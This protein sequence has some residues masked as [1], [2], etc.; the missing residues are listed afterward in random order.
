MNLWG[1]INGLMPALLQLAQDLFRKH[2]GNVAEATKEI[3]R[4]R[5]YGD[6]LVDAEGVMRAELQA[7]EDEDT[8]REK[9]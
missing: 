9:L 8:K 5:P 7:L 6:K 1:F 4:V 3:Q 2:R